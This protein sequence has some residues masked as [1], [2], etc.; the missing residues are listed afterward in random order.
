MIA[1]PDMAAEGAVVTIKVSGF[2]PGEQV[3]ISF[4]DTS[5]QMEVDLRNVTAGP[6][7]GFVAEVKVP[8]DRGD[9][10]EESKFRAWS[11]DD[12]DANNTADTPFTYID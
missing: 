6:D 1:S 8:R 11:V 2:A 7:G 10:F 9:G 5:P 12:V 4:R 3:R